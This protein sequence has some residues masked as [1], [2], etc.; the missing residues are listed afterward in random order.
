MEYNVKRLPH[1]YLVSDKD[2]G[3]HLAALSK[4]SDM[5]LWLSEHFRVDLP[6]P[7]WDKAPDG[8]VEWKGGEPPAIDKGTPIIVRH[9]DGEE[10]ETKML[11]TFALPIHWQCDESPY[12]IIAYKVCD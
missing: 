6:E 12:D 2:S 7:V 8:W 5:V 10:R 3:E 9:R 4:F 1:G 11:G